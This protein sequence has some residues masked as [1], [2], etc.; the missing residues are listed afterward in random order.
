MSVIGA[1]HL[2]YKM[3]SVTLVTFA[4]LLLSVNAG[5]LADMYEELASE[6]DD[7]AESQLLSKAGDH[8]E[9]GDLNEAT[10]LQ[11]DDSGD[12]RRL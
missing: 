8:D 6:F 11:Q 4:V 12:R 9:T 2:Y 1:I 5:R 3:K 10:Y 7:L